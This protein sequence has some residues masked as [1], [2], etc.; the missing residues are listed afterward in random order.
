MEKKH[1]FTGRDLRKLIIP[2]VMESLLNMTIGMADTIMVASCGEAAVSAVS[3]VDTVSLLFIQVFSAFATGGAV[4]IS[5]YLGKGDKDMARK[6]AANLLYITFAISMLLSLFLLPLRRGMI[7]KVFGSITPEVRTYTDQYFVPVIISYPFLALFSCLTATSRSEGNSART[8][9]VAFLMNA[10]NI[11]GNA[12]LIY[13]FGMG[14]Q[15]AGIASLASRIAGFFAMYFLMRKKTEDLSTSGMLGTPFSSMLA[16]KILRIAL[17]SGIEGATFQFG[18]IMVQSLIASLGTSAIAINAVTNNYNA[19]ANI[20]G[21]G[22]NLALITIIGQC[23]GNNNFRDISYY[24]RL[25]VLLNILST[26]ILS[27][28]LYIATPSFIALY[29]LEAGSIE[30]AIP[31][32][33]LCLISCTLLWS[34]AFTLPNTLK[35]VGDVKFILF[36][37][38]SSMWIFR[39]MLSFI[40]IKFFGFG[41]DGVW[42]SMYADW[43]FR[44]T[45][46]MI[47]YKSGRWKA[48]KV[49]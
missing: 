29:G 15:G 45:L 25:L 49:I 44:G 16:K 28:P 13:I 24:T 17:P 40:L 12:V 2:L 36:T 14:P 33:R 48:K 37:S 20:A 46:Y 8:M 39:V 35:A 41:V 4:V 34:F 7:G 22:I 27:V 21:N 3:L 9:A 43:I 31:I 47:R 42:Y 6:S 11:C 30:T 32:C 1:Q 26:F 19:Y 5:Q 38:I 18:K 23:R 10:I